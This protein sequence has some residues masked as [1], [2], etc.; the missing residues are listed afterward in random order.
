MPDAVS[1]YAGTQDGLAV[2]RPKN[3]GWETTNHVFR[4]QVVDAISGSKTT[5]ERVYAGVAY[6]GVYRTLDAG[7]T[8][9]KVLEGDIRSLAVDPTDDKVVYAGTEPPRLY[10]SEDRGDTW[11]EL[12]GLQ[13]LPDAARQR[14]WTPYPP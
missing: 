4:G 11:E 9:S 12:A 8:W 5:P 14:W 10:R 7:A 3:G 2:F 13:A 6:D 1:L